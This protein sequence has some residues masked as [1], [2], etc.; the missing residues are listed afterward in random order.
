MQLTDIRIKEMRK[1]S[2]I[3]QW[4]IILSNTFMVTL[5]CVVYSVYA[6]LHTTQC[7]C[8]QPEPIHVGVSI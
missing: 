4:G 7:A 3:A 6:K 2:A 5:P 1:Q 8:L